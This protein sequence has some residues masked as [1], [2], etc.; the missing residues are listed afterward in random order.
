MNPD[1]LVRNLLCIQNKS[2]LSLGSVTIAI[3]LLGKFIS[4]FSK[5]LIVKMAFVTDVREFQALLDACVSVR[6]WE[7]LTESIQIPEVMVPMAY[8]RLTEL[9]LKKWR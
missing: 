1:W 9:T 2:A 4:D 7:T 3:R 8:A 6:D 5:L